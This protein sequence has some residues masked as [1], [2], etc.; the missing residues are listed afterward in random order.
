MNPNKLIWFR[1]DD[2]TYKGCVA[3]SYIPLQV[4]LTHQI[5]IVIID[6]GGKFSAIVTINKLRISTIMEMCNSL[7][8]IMEECQIWWFNRVKQIK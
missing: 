4:S 5:R 6:N 7:E 1:G 2:M 8:R 3:Y